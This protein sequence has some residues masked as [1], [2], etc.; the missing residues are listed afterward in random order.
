MTDE[1]KKRI[2]ITGVSPAPC[3]GDYTARGAMGE[4]FPITAN[5]FTDGHD[6]VSASVYIKAD[7]FGEWQEVP[8]KQ[9]ENDRWHAVFF[10]P[11]P[12]FYQYRIDARVDHF[13]TWR[14]G[15]KK[16]QADGQDLTIEMAI[17]AQLLEKAHHSALGESDRQQLM[18]YAANWADPALMAE[19]FLAATGKPLATLMR[20]FREPDLVTSYCGEAAFEIERK[21]SAYS[22]WYELFPR[23]A[24]TEPGRHGTFQDVTRLLPRI[25]KMGFDVLYLP[26]IHPIGEKN[27]K[28]KN[29]SLTPGPDEPG[30]PWAIGNRK[31]GHKSIHPELGT[32]A[33]FKK[34]IKE[35]RRN[36]LEIA[37]DIAYQCA[38]DHPYVKQ[39]PQW[40][41]WRPDGSVQYAENPPKKYE[42][43]LPFDF[44]TEDWKNLW[45]ELKSVI[46]HWIAAGVSIFR[47][48]N[49]HTKSFRFWAW[50]IAKTRQA[51]PE[52]IFLAE[53][54]TRPRV[55]EQLAKAGFNQSYTYFTW[56][57]NK[58]EL[59][60]YMTTL[61]KTEMRYYFRPN[62]WPNTPD[63]LPPALVNGGENAHIMRLI[64]AATLSANYGL[65]GPVYEFGINQPHGNK[66]EY[67]DNEKYEVRHWDWQAYTRIGEIIKRVNRIR[68]DNPALQSTWNLE[69]AKTSNDQIIC[70]AKYDPATNNLMIVAVNLD[71]SQTQGAHV[72]IPFEKFGLERPPQFLLHDLLSG[73][74]YRW[75][76][77]WN[78]IELN[79]YQ[80]PAHILRVVQQ[81]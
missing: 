18:S 17:G 25:A 68:R 73:E 66:E 52:I 36:G 71:V 9:A 43:I 77:D 56:R 81:N 40:F 74:K 76:E 37:M 8:M 30:S 46:D 10:P 59:E 50:L 13:T 22:T 3:D 38:P 6:Q 32:L 27:R 31:G 2:I 79:P 26:P 21:R 45:L 39:F 64:L 16:K 41:K 1:G 49:P 58:K 75:Q 78:Y 47:I 7:K 23:S 53:A 15:L 67:I 20:Q 42:D 55:M 35:A 34:L 33:D 29:N 70:Y 12:G 65:Y 57:N 19:N 63:I 69:F 48:D 60:E 62:F 44:E 72:Q 5:I 51:H 4:P 11:A 24:S 54:F 61:T 28:G 14:E 80:M